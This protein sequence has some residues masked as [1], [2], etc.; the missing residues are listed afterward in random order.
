MV[1]K[2]R[3]VRAFSE[4]VKRYPKGTASLFSGAG[5]KA[6][7]TGRN[8]AIALTKRHIHPR[9]LYAKTMG[10]GYSDFNPLNNL[11]T[12]ALVNPAAVPGGSSQAQAQAGASKFEN[13]VNTLL[14]TAN[15]AADIYGKFKN[16]GAD[17]VMEPQA[18][19]AQGGKSIP[20]PLIAAGAG[21]VIVL[22]VVLIMLKKK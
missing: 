21:L 2:E 22:V 8:L 6:R 5:I 12:A 13:I 4:I 17:P 16:P 20:W 11:K 9:Q 3:A 19:A 1:S 15:Q 7:P 10:Y 18:A 14:G